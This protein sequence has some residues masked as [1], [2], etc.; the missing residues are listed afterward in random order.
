MTCCWDFSLQNQF[1]VERAL[2]AADWS[3]HFED[4]RRFVLM[5]DCETACVTT[6]HNHFVYLEGTVEGLLSQDAVCGGG[7]HSDS[8]PDMSAVLT[9][10]ALRH[11]VQ[12]L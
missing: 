7:Y 3:I 8:S 2:N 9:T 1:H 11:F 6:A 12:C 5:E 4:A 10:T